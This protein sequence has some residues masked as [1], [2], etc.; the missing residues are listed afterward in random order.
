MGLIDQ[1]VSGTDLENEKLDAMQGKDADPEA[2]FAKENWGV[3]EGA[4][5]DY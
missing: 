2:K 1:S 4:Q 3:E 5:R